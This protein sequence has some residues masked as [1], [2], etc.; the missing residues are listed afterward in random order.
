LGRRR[1]GKMKSKS[2]NKWEQVVRNPPEIYRDS[3][4]EEKRFLEKNI[5]KDSL[6]LDVGCGDGRLF[7]F[8]AKIS[9]NIVAIDNDP[10]AIEKAQK[11][12]GKIPF[13][14]VLLEDAEKTNFED[15]YF[16][17][18]ILAGTFCN[19]GKTKMRVLMEL[20]RILKE[21]G[22]LFLS[23]YNEDALEKRLIL[24]K[25]LG[26]EIKSVDNKGTVIMD[27]NLI[28]EQFFKK[29]LK[30]ILSDAKFKVI[31][32]IKVGIFYLIKAKKIEDGR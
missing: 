9:D 24:Y 20:R 10:V 12:A 19:L 27:G 26:S 31:D 22:I 8:L 23:T 16:D 13:I 32:I 5:P 14:R 18:I 3:M 1:V 17:I 30:D 2:I 11:A 29:E 25:K 7:D 21:E 6:I 15:N 4:E 28:S